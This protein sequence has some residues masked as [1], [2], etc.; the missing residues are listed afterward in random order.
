M[1][2]AVG[3]PEQETPIF[4][5]N[6]VRPRLDVYVWDMD[7]TL[8]LLNSL[9]KSSYAEAFNGLKDVQKGVEIGRMWENLILQTCDDYFFYEQ[10]EN[11]NKPFLDA[12]AQYDDGSDLSD[13]DFNK[14]ELGAPQDDANK[15]KLAY[16]HRVIAQ[17]YI[18]GLQNILDQE[19][20]KHWDEL[21]DKTDEYTDRWLSSARTFLKECLG[22]DEDAVSSITSSDTSYNSTNVKHVNVLV[23]SGSLIPSLVKCLLFRLDSLISHGNVYSSWEVGK[24]QC[25]RWINERFN[26]PNV[27]FCVFG[28]G[29][30]ECEAAEIMRWP[31]VKIDPRPGKLHRF[32][33]LTLTTVSHY[34]SVVYGRPNNENEDG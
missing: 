8:V 28:D 20:I 2:G 21:Y 34:F 24:I 13:Y 4:S 9:L 33:G 3:M 1:A 14:D 16:R 19:T 10:I 23:T 26:H 18:Q 25:F 29:W 11:Y 12:L 17:K 7:E 32:P 30:E 31:F 27:R 15:R 5:G 22:E 6:N